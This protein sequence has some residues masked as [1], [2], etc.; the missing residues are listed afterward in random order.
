[1]QRISKYLRVASLDGNDILTSGGTEGLVSGTVTGLVPEEDGRI[2]G[3]VITLI[4]VHISCDSKKL[5]LYLFV[6]L[7]KV[8]FHLPEVEVAEFI[9][10]IPV[11]N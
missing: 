1:M 8:R 11:V 10:A 7:L 2:M 5:F 9:G 6:I 4:Y 3:T